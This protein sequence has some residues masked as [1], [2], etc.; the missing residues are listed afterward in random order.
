MRNFM[1]VSALTLALIFSCNAGE[2][3][4]D[5]AINVRPTGKKPPTTSTPNK[6]G[7]T[8][9]PGSN[10][11]IVDDGGSISP[12]P[13]Y[14]SCMQLPKN[15]KRGYGQCGD[16]EV[17]VIVNDGQ[18]KEMTCCPLASPIILSQKPDERYITRSGRCQTNEVLTGMVSAQGTGYCTKI[19]T[20]LVK[21]STSVP[22]VY[23]TGQFAGILGE[24]ARSYNVS[25]TCICPEATVAIGGHT[26]QDNTCTE[27][28]VRIQK[29]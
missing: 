12:L 2:F 15:G 9:N 10:E 22:S 14:T 16:N 11:L 1:S 27:Q 13:D 8:P 5:G 26:P 24:I 28:C 29:K 3:A 19:N 6:P 17:V 21:L 18:A 20:S 25:D 23:A 4:G 7:D